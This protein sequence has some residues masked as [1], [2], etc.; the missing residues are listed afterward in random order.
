MAISIDTE[1]MQVIATLLTAIK[2]KI[3]DSANIVS[4]IAE[5]NDWQC[6]ERF[7][8]SERIAKNKREQKKVQEKITL[9]SEKVTIAASQFSTIDAKTLTAFRDLNSLFSKLLSVSSSVVKGN[10]VESQFGKLMSSANNAEVTDPL[11]SY[12]LGGIGEPIRVCRFDD[13]IMNSKE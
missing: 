4:H 1:E 13:I 7:A 5:H 3:D 10:S 8:I 9:F 6:K 11:S 2:E 12:A